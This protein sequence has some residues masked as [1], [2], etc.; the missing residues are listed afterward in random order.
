[1]RGLRP[2]SG[3][4]GIPAGMVKSD[5][6]RRCG[7]LGTLEWPADSGSIPQYRSREQEKWF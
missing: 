3:M 5:R 1:M 6:K 2:I 4:V 7:D